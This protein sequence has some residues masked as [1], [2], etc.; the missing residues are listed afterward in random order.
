MSV[1]SYLW[2]VNFFYELTLF[3]LLQGLVELVESFFGSLKFIEG[4]FCANV[5]LLQLLDSLA[6]LSFH[7]SLTQYLSLLYRMLSSKF[8]KTYLSSEVFGIF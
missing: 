3:L 6:W 8:S 7:G 4:L 5:A 2:V 1:F